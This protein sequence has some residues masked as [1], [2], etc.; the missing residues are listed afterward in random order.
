MISNRNTSRRPINLRDMNDSNMKMEL[1]EFVGLK[2]PCDEK[3]DCNM[4]NMPI[5]MAYVPF[6][7]DSEVYTCEKALKQGTVFPALDK[8]FTMGCMG[9]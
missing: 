2:T 1:N 4:E 8:P 7:T 9:C 6:Q 5:A 3:I